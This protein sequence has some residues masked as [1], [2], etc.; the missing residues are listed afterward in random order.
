MAGARRGA[1]NEARVADLVAHFVDNRR[2]FE[3]VLDQ[4][5]SNLLHD[6]ALLANVHSFKWRIKEP[7]SLR[8][9]LN[10]KRSDAIKAGQ[11]FDYTKENLFLKVNDLVG[12]RILHLHTD[13]ME[14]I[15]HALQSRLREAA[16]YRI[17]EGPWART[18]DD[19]TRA[20][21]KSI[22]IKTKASPTLYTSVHYVIKTLTQ[23]K[24]TCEIQVRTLA[25]ELWGEV[26]HTVN[27][28]EESSS[29]PCREQIAVLARLTSGCSRLVDSIFRT[30]KEHVA[31]ADLHPHQRRPQKR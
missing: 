5:R 28:P 3:A 7:A 20:Y 8:E 29:M 15:D 9:K 2:E 17:I 25:E 19:E 6:R 18:W 24:Y 22:G 1:G 10:G 26:N 23:T 11:P 31:G 27:Y 30:H 12:V 4:L 16:V 14:E 21:F 13:Q